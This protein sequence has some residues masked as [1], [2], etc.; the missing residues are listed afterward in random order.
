MHRAKPI[1]LIAIGGR[2]REA[3]RMTIDATSRRTKPTA[4]CAGSA[5]GRDD[6][7]FAKEAT[8]KLRGPQPPRT[9]VER[10]SPSTTADPAFWKSSG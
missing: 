3:A 10:A 2:H 9:A 1:V 4:S 5:G 8:L 7:H 6:D